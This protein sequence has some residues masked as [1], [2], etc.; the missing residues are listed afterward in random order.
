MR[1]ILILTENE[2]RQAVSLD[3]TLIDLIA[4]AFKKLSA[5]KVSMPPILRMD[6]EDK[7][8][9][10]DVK[11]A[12]VPGLDGFAIKISPGFFDNPKIGLPTTS[13]L[14]VV[15]D[16]TTGQVRAVL[17]D[18]GYLTD[19]RT[20][21]AGAV[22]AR[23]LA[24]EGATR[25]GVIGTGV[26]ARLQ[27][28]ALA[29]VRP[30]DTVHVWGRDADKAK[31]CAQDIE[32]LTSATVTVSSSIAGLVRDSDIVVTTTPSRKPLIDASML[33]P[34]LHITAMG[35]DAEHKN[36]LAPDVIAEAD[37]FTCDRHSQS[38]R[39]GELH[40]A[41]GA[42]IVPEDMPVAEL[43]AILSTPKKGRK[44]ASDVTICDLTGTGVQDTAI[45]IH[46]LSVAEENGFGTKI[47]N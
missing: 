20:A 25:A 46:T 14:M 21:A 4:D 22:A 38:A 6:M 43:G 30:I 15:H 12:Y 44:S 47:S 26:Q 27:M 29:M 33:H 45:A 40:H 11:T 35:S 16:A 5:G 41:V 19:M 9:E 18:N 32:R 23:C 2:L 36:E 28:Q 34:G 7:N 31:A 37:L 13:G 10:V 3:M 17:L 42:G 1:E 8:G 39:L 24:P